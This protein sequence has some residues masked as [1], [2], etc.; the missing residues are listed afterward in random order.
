MNRD[1]IIGNWKQFKGEVQQ[2]WGA[3]T[4]DQIEQV[5]GD[6]TKLAGK[7]QEA[8]GVAREEAEEQIRQWEEACK[9]RHAA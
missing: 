4:N 3:L 7:I 5:N 6:R 9:R 2:Q 1:Q 8:Y